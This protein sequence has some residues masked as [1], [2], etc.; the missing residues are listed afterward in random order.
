MRTDFWHRQERKR[1][2]LGVILRNFGPPLSGERLRPGVQTRPGQRGR[3]LGPI[4][5][6]LAW[7]AC[8]PCRPDRDISV[9]S[10]GPPHQVQPAPVY[11]MS[12]AS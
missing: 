3:D 6:P 12:P 4:P 8:D 9:N 5:N 2:V 1:I 11:N 7:P 10:A